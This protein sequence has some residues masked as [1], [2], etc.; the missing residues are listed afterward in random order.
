[1]T[2]RSATPTVKQRRVGAQLRRWREAADLGLR[3]AATRAG[4]DFTRLSRLERVQYR[5]PADDVRK[6]AKAYGVDDE[7]AVEAVVAA[8]EEPPGRGWW[9]P[10]VGLL[11]RP[12][13]DFI[14]LESDATGLR[15]HHPAVV[16]GLAQTPGY[17]RELI[18]RS[19]QEVIEERAESLVAA[20][21]GRQEILARAGSRVQVR[22]LVTESALHAEFESGPEIMRD[23]IHRLLDLSQRPGITVQ[24]LP[25]G[26]HPSYGSNGALTLLDFDHP[27]LPAA[28][29]DSPLGG[30]HTDDPDEV[31]R[32]GAEFEFIASAALPA[33]DSRGLLKAHLERVNQ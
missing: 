1:M 32:L 14:E 23:Q 12:Y 2:Q 10:Y 13:L 3:E 4:L 31:T 19:A 27:W 33:D 18:R 11:G 8:A 21:L 9:A 17:A 15:V 24:I 29:V 20:R 25:L 6:L 16:P 7:Q 5:V 22:F 28:S 30:E 26:M